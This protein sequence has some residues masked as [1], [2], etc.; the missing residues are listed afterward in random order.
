MRYVFILNPAAGKGKEQKRIINAINS[1]FSQFGGVYKIIQTTCKNEATAI[2]EKEAKTGDSVC[3]FAGGGEGT[4]FEVLNGIIGYDNVSMGVIP[5][6]SANDFLKFFKNRD[7]FCNI[8]DQI[9]GGS[10]KVDLIKAGEKYCLNSCSVGM[11]AMVANDMSLFKRIPF[12]KGSLAYNLAIIKNFL[13]KI[14]VKMRITLDGEDLGERNVL[15][16]VIA[17]APYYGG[18]Y[19]GAPDAVP[20]DQKLNFTMVD[21]VGRIKILKFL[22]EY[23]K[24]TQGKLDICHMKECSSLH[25][26]ADKPLPIN[27]DGEIIK[28]NNIKFEIVKQGLNLWLP[29][30]VL[31]KLLTKV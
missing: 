28:Q 29:E 12:V 22:P 23:K 26:T 18:G 16:S 2:A 17:N 19:I 14:G 9:H 4:S 5:C 20:F 1:Y 24:G 15:F 21:T 7:A 10:I 27:L 25:I 11:D 8:H 31:S 13:G 30:S 3:I 6:G